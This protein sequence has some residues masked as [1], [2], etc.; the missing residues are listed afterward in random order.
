MI[1]IFEAPEYTPFDWWKQDGSVEPRTQNPGRKKKVLHP[2][3]AQMAAAEKKRA[4]EA[5]EAAT[6]NRKR[7]AE[8]RK[9]DK[10]LQKQERTRQGRRKK[11]KFRNHG[12]K[13]IFGYTP[14]TNPL[15]PLGQQGFTSSLSR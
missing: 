5:K 14:S 9:Q 12:G 1:P 15:P 10:L 4:K 2:L 3:L 8:Q 7:V 11:K 6:A 13:Q